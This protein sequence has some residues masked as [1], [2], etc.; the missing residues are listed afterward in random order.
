MNAGRAR[1]LAAIW[2]VLGLPQARGCWWTV[3]TRGDSDD[4]PVKGW[5]KG[6]G[7]GWV[8]TG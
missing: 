6:K 1:K 8:Y 7:W 5:Q 2:G 4:A 3:A